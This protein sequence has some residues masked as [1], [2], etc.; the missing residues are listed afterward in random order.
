MYS[1]EFKDNKGN[2]LLIP[3]NIIYPIYY[4]EKLAELNENTM[5]SCIK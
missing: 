4:K 5:Y 2:N 3:T 1:Y